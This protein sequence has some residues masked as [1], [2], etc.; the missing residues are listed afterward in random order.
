M[1]KKEDPIY[2]EAIVVGSGPAAL[3]SIKVLISKGLYPLVLDVG[4]VKESIPDEV[5]FESANRKS[6]GR[7]SLFGSHFPYYQFTHSDVHYE[8]NEPVISF[9]A[10]G[11]S[12][13]WGATFNI[14]FKDWPSE[15]IPNEE[16]INLV[17]GM[18]Y[19]SKIGGR[20]GD[21][22][23]GA[24]SLEQNSALRSRL[25]SSRW[26]VENAKL[27][28]ES[29]GPSNKCNRCNLCISGCPQGSIWNARTEIEKLAKN[30][31]ID[32]RKSHYVKRIISQAGVDSLEVLTE[33]L[34]PTYFSSKFIFL[35]AG[36]IS[37]AAILMRSGVS[38]R[39]EIKD[40]STAYSVLVKPFRRIGS[41]KG[42]SLSHTWVT[43]QKLHAKHQFYPPSLSNSPKVLSKLPRLLRLR[44]LSDLISASIYPVISYLPERNS[45]QII[46]K[47]SVSGIQVTTLRFNSTRLLHRR[48]KMALAI[49]VFMSGYFFLPFTMTITPPGSGYHFGK[50]STFKPG[51]FK[52]GSVA[53]F[54]SL[55]IVDASA[56]CEIPVG[57]ITPIMMTNAAR[58][59]RERVLAEGEI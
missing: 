19:E 52:F 18:M 36:A 47:K 25:R 4:I 41:T 34:E 27:A 38:S 59:T 43:D 44:K 56:L 23:P 16:D 45:G 28:I 15:L 26:K 1:M 24:L 22:N 51:D 37:S 57:S 12:N 17:R 13:V 6:P 53:Q 10:G 42:I 9:A 40:S 7:K 35:G 11:L 54:P 5:S 55:S 29:N 14:D 48:A 49:R 8:Q 39:I 58:I 31:A 46:L 30:G 21:L 33:E 50:L 2:A 32:Y 20:L 3:S